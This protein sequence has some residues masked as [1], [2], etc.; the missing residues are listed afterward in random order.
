MNSRVDLQP[1]W[2]R[3]QSVRVGDLQIALLEGFG[4]GAPLEEKMSIFE[5]IS[6]F[7]RP[8]WTIDPPLASSQ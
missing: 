5:H 4:G 6:T 2:L 7:L 8:N 3:P 1:T